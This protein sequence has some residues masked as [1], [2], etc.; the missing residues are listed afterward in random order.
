MDRTQFFTLVRERPA[1]ELEFLHEAYWL[2]KRAHAKQ[3]PRKTG[4]PYVVHPKAVAVILFEFGYKDTDTLA[5]SF[6][7]DAP[8]DTD[9]PPRIIVKVMGSKIWGWV[10]TL[11]KSIAVKDPVTGHT[12]ARA[13]KDLVVYYKAIFDAPV[14]VRRIK[15]ADAIQNMGDIDGFDPEHGLRFIAKTEKFVLPIADITCPRMAAEIRRLCTEHK[16][17]LQGLIDLASMP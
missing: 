7:H 2:Y 17:R 13:V 4:D 16:T 5:A 1:E 9:I 12:I 11:S 8:E 6:L 14:E 3:A 15:C 10:E